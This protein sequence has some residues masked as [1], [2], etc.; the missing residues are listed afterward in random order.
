MSMKTRAGLPRGWALLYGV[1]MVGEAPVMAARCVTTLVVAWVALRATGHDGAGAWGWAK[2]GGADGVVAGG[3]G[4]AGGGR[5]VVAG[6][7]GWEAAGGA[8]GGGL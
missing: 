4:V 2:L 1:T 7:D 3:A 5:L 8:R 6:A